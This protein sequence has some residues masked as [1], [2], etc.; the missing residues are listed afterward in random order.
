MAARPD[1][2]SD[3]TL[4]AGPPDPLARPR[5][6]TSLYEDGIVAGVIGAGTVALWFLVLDSLAGRPLY[7]PTVLGT[8]LFRRGAGLDVPEALPISLEMVGMFTWVHAL[9]FVLIGG[10]A[11]WLLTVAERNPSY[12]FGVLLLFV[13]F[14]AGFIAAAMLTAAPVLKALGWIA[15]LAANLLAAATMA[16]YLGWRHRGMRV[17]P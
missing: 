4:E 6:V 10:L 2:T 3:S 11:S 1:L 17:D 15:I 8:A 5:P 13:V 7:T 12:G 9:A 16:A 14:Q